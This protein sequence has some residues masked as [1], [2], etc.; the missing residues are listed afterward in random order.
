MSNTQLNINI[1]RDDPTL[2]DFL[3]CWSKFDS[4]PNKVVVYNTY[5]AL[6]FNNVLLQYNDKNIL[7]EIIP[8]EDSFI[9][10]DKVILKINDG[11]YISY[12]QIDRNSEESIINELCFFYK[13]D[14]EFKEIQGIIDLINNCSVSFCDEENSKIVTLSIGQNGL[15]VDP[16]TLSNDNLDNIEMFYNHKTFKSINKLIKSIK[17]NKKGL[18]VFYGKKGTGK[19]SIINYLSKSLDSTI[20]FIPNNMIDLTINNPEFKRFLKRYKNPVIIIDDCEMMFNE[21][22]TRSNILVNNLIQLVD[23]ILS[24]SIGLQIITMFNVDNDD[25]IDHCLLDCNNLL[26]VVEFNDLDCDESTELSKYIKRDKKYKSDVRLIDVIK[27]N[28]EGYKIDS[29]L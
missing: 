6:E 27:G 13:S 20:I 15:E 14:S 3:F 23:G 8:D 18:S 28:K 12:V 5:S 1:N 22:Y 25:H 10:N 21:S 19:T 24:D 17:K 7:T 4:R 11:L 2:N 26:N 16:I 9:I 29:Y